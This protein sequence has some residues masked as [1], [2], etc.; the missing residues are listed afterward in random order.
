MEMTKSH[1][2]DF[3]VLKNSVHLMWNSSYDNDFLLTWQKE[4]YAD[5]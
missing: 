4:P 1:V 2:A 3:Y 5:E